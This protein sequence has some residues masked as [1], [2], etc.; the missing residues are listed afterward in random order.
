L[1]LYMAARSG[2]VESTMGMTR[3]GTLA[4]SSRL[5]WDLPRLYH[6]TICSL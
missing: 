5:A 2:E 4:F 6:L 3:P 1:E